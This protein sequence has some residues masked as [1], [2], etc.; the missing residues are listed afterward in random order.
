MEKEDYYLG[1]GFIGSI[2]SIGFHCQGYVF[3]F[4]LASLKLFKTEEPV[5][6]LSFVISLLLLIFNFQKIIRRRRKK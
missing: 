2:L 1:L 3:E 6:Y 4:D 5:L